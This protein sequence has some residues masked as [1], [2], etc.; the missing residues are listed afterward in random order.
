MS[1]RDSKFS[2]AYDLHETFSARMKNAPEDTGSEVTVYINEH[3]RILGRSMP[4]GSAYSFSTHKDT[5][6]ERSWWLTPR[7]H[8]DALLPGM[9]V[10]F[11]AIG[12][13]HPKNGSIVYDGQV[14]VSHR[15][16]T[17]GLP[18]SRAALQSGNAD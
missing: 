8:T 7:G 18:Y 5:R 11:E 1:E 12:W 13:A 16:P 17:T 3:H 9:S 10:Y 4:K 2:R 14:V 6:Q 15:G